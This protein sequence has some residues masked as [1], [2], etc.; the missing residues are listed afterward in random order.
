MLVNLT[1]DISKSVG[2]T[3][4]EEVDKML[5]LFATNSE[6]IET[7]FTSLHKRI[8]DLEHIIK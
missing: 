3:L 6:S 4:T 1:A 8:D 5:N 2:G 7:N